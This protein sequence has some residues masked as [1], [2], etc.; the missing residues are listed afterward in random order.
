MEASN[1]PIYS[2][3]QSVLSELTDVNDTNTSTSFV[4][5]DKIDEIVLKLNMELNKLNA[6][7]L[8]EKAKDLGIASLSK[9]KKPEII[10]LLET[11]FL[12]LL[13]VLKDK[14]LNELKNICKQYGIKGFAGSKKD[15]LIYHILL[16]SSATLKFTVD[17]AQDVEPDTAG[18]TEPAP[19]SIIE[20]L[21]KQKL[22]IEHRLKEEE[23]RVQEEKRL[24]EEKRV[25]EAKDKKAKEDEDAAKI[26][27]DEEKKET[28]KKKQ[29]IPKNVRIIVW[30]HY[31]SEDIIKHKCLCCKKVTISNTSFEV[32]HVIS[33]KNG[34]THE[35]NNLRPICF[36]CNHSMG[37]EN[38]V[39]FVV[40]YGLYI[41]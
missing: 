10:Q 14:K 29:S 39:D 1:L 6:D 34:G 40:K 41:G 2:D 4:I 12:K 30:N 5:E 18:K 26:K 7:S 27:E 16:H 21:E 35:I 20:Q 33:E 23:K 22:D 25:Q 24:Q 37:T 28:K 32:G 9:L 19:L 17:I 13:P 8:K 11:V 31:I 15:L 36:A 38:M 3:N